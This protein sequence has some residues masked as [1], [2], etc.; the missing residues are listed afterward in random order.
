MNKKKNS[1]LRLP[2][3]VIAFALLAALSV[4]AQEKKRVIIW[5]PYLVAT[6]QGTGPGTQF[7]SVADAVE[8]VSIEAG[9]HPIK[10]GQSFGADDDWLGTLTV[11]LKNISGQA[12]AVA[13]ISFTLPETEAPDQGA[14][15]TTLRYGTGSSSKQP[16]VPHKLI[17]PDEVFELK[18]T[19][20]AYEQEKSTILQRGLST[21][22]IKLWIGTTMVRFEDGKYW[23][24]GCLKTSDPANACP[25]P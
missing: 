10:V 25:A 17:A 8:I 11:R 16:D 15:R 7:S 13:Q 19:G 24:R 1:R 2:V 21:G 14:L 4:H 23:S 5:P 12:I 9:G 18:L 6:I 3:S 20:A 22:V